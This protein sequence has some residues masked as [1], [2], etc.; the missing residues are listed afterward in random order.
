MREG[1]ALPVVRARTLEE[2]Q[3]AAL[4]MVGGGEWGLK[5]HGMGQSQVHVRP[6]LKPIDS[7]IYYFVMTV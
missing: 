5:Q 4:C 1:A 2:P 6:S 3:V 7:R